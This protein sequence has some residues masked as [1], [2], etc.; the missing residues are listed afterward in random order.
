MK[1]ARLAAGF[2]AA[3]LLFV[4]LAAWA[5]AS[6][7]GAEPDADYHLARYYCAAGQAECGPEETPREGACYGMQPWVSAECS[8]WGSRTVPK[9][10]GLLGGHYPPFYYAAMAPAVG[11][12]I[13]QTT[14]AVRLGNSFLAVLLAGIAVALT[15]PALRWAVVA[16]G[17]IAA[18]PL[19]VYFIAS[20]SPSA[21]AMIG[22]AVIWG[23]LLTLL[24][25]LTG[26]GAGWR[27]RQGTAITIARVAFVV[28]A[29]WFALAGRS[30]PQAFLPIAAA[31]LL[32]FSWPRKP[33]RRPSPQQ[34]VGWATASVVVGLSVLF[35]V[36]YSLNYKGT[37]TSK[38]DAISRHGNATTPR[39]E[40]W[41]VVQR[42]INNILGFIGFPAQPGAG[43]GTY[44]VPVPGL[45]ATAVVLAYLG[46]AL[47]G[48]SAL[49]GRKIAAIVVYAGGAVGL[50]SWFWSIVGW[51]YFQPRYFMPL[52]FL[53]LGLLLVPRPDNYP[54]PAATP[55]AFGDTSGGT[56][57]GMQN[58]R[59][60]GS[61]LQW[62]VLLA[63]LAVAN[64]FIMLS[65]LL[66]FMRGVQYQDARS[67]LGQIAP[68]TNPM[69]LANAAQP[70][71]WWE[72]LPV[73]P[74][75]LWVIGS[76]AMAGTLA[77]VWWAFLE[78]RVKATQSASVAPPIRDV[79]REPVAV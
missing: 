55:G 25:P 73:G 5:F 9:T 6:P 67:P 28:F 20:S 35:Y 69:E 50:I 14:M 68:Q 75:G 72:S 46:A 11:D 64:S 32:M 61:N 47:L 45:A 22:M 10:D 7:V 57:S 13:A 59:R 66:R 36:V 44:D 34:W 17:L 43:L 40:D 76:L 54:S 4:S 37:G 26:S 78:P 21:W 39:Y 23:P 56:E 63:V 29:A 24:A 51:E 31:G 79:E 60:L 41:D 19:G 48:L 2:G 15:A 8:D 38:L 1:G 62:A 71:W 18:I 42:T 27:Y 58:P 77:L 3:V 70:S 53:F 74:F 33:L 52:S 12:T 30:E 16:S 65:T 49:Y